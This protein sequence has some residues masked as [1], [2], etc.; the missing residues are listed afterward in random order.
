[1]EIIVQ[2]NGKLQLE[3]NQITVTFECRRKNKSADIATDMGVSTFGKLSKL[4]DDIGI[5]S[6]NLRT[7]CCKLNEHQI[8]DE[9]KR[10]YVND[11]YEFYQSAK[12][13]FNLDMD[14][15]SQMREQILKL[16]KDSPTY[17]IT[18]E[19]N[20]AD[21]ITEEILKQAFFDAEFQAKSIALAGGKQVI[22]C[23][24]VS[25]EPFDNKTF[26]SDTEMDVNCMMVKSRSTTT[27]FTQTLIPDKITV[28]KTIYC[29]FV[30]K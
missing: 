12:I 28:T 13:T 18:F 8:Y 25:F 23:T 2:G 4:L 30:A 27:D 24:K 20:D 26:Y 16:G 9:S 17:S 22:E 1:M 15:L 21:S 7:T 19:R 14:K 5:S 3:P 10:K 29:S 11:C 6:R